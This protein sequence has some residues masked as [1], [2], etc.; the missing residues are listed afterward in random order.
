VSRLED[1][2]RRD[3]SAQAGHITSPSVPRLRLPGPAGRQARTPWHRGVR[4]RSGWLIPLA[5]AGAVTALI[6]ATFIAIPLVTSAAPRAPHAAPPAANAPRGSAAHYVAIDGSGT[7]WPSVAI[8]QWAANLRPAG[9]V[10]NFNP[11]G[12]ATGR[13]D[14]MANKDDLTASDQPFRSGVDKLGGTGPEHPAQG[15]SYIPDVAGAT[16]FVYHIDVGG[17]LITHLR[18]SAS[19]L[20]GIFTGQITNWDSPQITR[21]NGHQLP[22]MRITPVIHAEGDGGTYF[23]TNWMAH[24]F[25]SQWNAFCDRV[26]PGIKPPCGPTEFYPQFGNAKAENGSN[27]VMVYLGSTPGNGAIGYVNY[28]Y[29]FNA[30]DPVAQVRNPAGRYVLPTAANITTALTQAIINTDPHSRNFLQ[31]DLTRLYTYTNPH[32]YPLA[33]YSYLIVPRA[34]TTLPTHFTKA[35]GHTLRAFVSYALCQGQR[36][37]APLGYAPLPPALVRGGLRQAAHIPGRGPIPTPAQCALTH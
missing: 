11:D 23:F 5:A 26:H 15:Y 32:S 14:Y 13:A 35:K 6:I 21:D 18:L 10:I 20:M 4:R 16:A 37:L 22:N 27:N 25:P 8:D 31:Q 24:V 3:L 29:A 1:R 33:S 28:A 12:S 19:T 30:H 17:H 34:G 2:L 9:I 7:S 36:H